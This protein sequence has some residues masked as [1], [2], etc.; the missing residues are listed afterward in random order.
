MQSY[1]QTGQNSNVFT[2]FREWRN[3]TA[4]QLTNREVQ[5]ITSLRNDKTHADEALFVMKILLFVV[6]IFTAYCG[7]LF[8]QNTFEKIFS[9][10]ATLFTAVALGIAT[11][12]AK[13]FLTHRALRSVFFGWMFK[14]TWSLGGWLFVFAIG[15]GAYYWSVSVSTDGMDMLTRE[16]TEKSTPKSDLTAAIGAATADIDR[17]ISAAENAQ[18]QGLNT[19]WKNTTTRGGQKIAATAALS[20]QTL[21]EQRRTLVDQVAADH[22]EENATRAQNI[23]NWAY[24]I[25]RYGGYMELV[26]GLC[27]ISIVFF[28]RRLVAA[29]LKQI[30]PSP[31]PPQ[32]NGIPVPQHTPAQDPTTPAHNGSALFSNAT[33]NPD[34]E[35][36]SLTGT[37]PAGPVPTTTDNDFIELR[38]KKLKGW[39]ANFGATGNKPDTVALNLCKLYNEIGMKLQEPNFQPSPEKMTELQDY[40]QNTGFPILNNNGYQYQYE[41]EFLTHCAQYQQR[42]MAPAA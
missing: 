40:A 1:S 18:K 7:F 34:R 12:L 4:E 42:R 39:G 38:L 22:R 33:P 30:P 37:N 10:R 8:Y 3:K 31:T 2:Q 19:K 24:W 6:T 16:L 23:S 5:K 14:D 15:A 28:E 25:E 20:I 41:N 9:P 13:S 17:Q 29:N 21:Q 27:L 32:R 36:F 35:R 26:A 11:E